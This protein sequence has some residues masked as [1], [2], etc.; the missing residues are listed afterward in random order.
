MISYL[1]VRTK[2]ISH[3][4]YAQGKGCIH[5]SNYTALSYMT[6]S[7]NTRPRLYLLLLSVL[8]YTSRVTNIFLT[9]VNTTT[10]MKTETPTLADQ[11][12]ALYYLMQIA[13]NTSKIKQ[14]TRNE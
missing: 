10:A 3:C 6:I 5:S 14:K 11:Y 13:G 7:R 4:I 9:V 12:Q 2:L 8:Q 1:L